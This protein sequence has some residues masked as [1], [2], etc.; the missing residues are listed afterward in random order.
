MVA[1]GVAL[2][3]QHV[4]RTLEELDVPMALMGGIALAA[5]NRT[6]FTQDVDLLIGV[7]EIDVQQVIESVREAGIRPIHK[8]PVITIGELDLIQCMYEPPDVFIEFRIDLLTAS[9]EFHRQA[10]ERRI[11][12]KLPDMDLELDIMSCEDLIVTK[13][14]AGRIID[15]ADSAVLLRA[16]RQSLDVKYLVQWCRRLELDSEFAEIWDEAF[17][18]ES[19]PVSSSDSP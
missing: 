4:W 6:R 1:K 19:P 13:L 14:S 9:T 10:L 16:N 17:P 12:T 3:L 5:W 18:G 15:R 8:P 2:A 11:A 7:E